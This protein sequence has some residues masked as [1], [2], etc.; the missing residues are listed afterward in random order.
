[1]GKI[2]PLPLP[3]V[4]EAGPL[5]LAKAC[6]SLRKLS[7]TSKACKGDS[8]QRVVKVCENQQKLVKVC[9]ILQKIL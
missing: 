4:E 1:V 7:K 6:E 2:S 8:L 3:P 9:K 5:R